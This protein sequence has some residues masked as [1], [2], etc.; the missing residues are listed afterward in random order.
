MSIEIAPA[1]GPVPAKRK[2]LMRR[3]FAAVADGIEN[4]AAT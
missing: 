4:R 2:M 3:A 1:R